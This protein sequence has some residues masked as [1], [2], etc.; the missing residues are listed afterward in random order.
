MLLP[1]KKIFFNLLFNISLFSL[2]LIGI[3]NSSDRKRVNLIYIETIKLP[4]SFIIGMSFISG[5]IAGG[6][7]KISP[8][9]KKK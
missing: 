7:L 1:L 6:L 5:S 3:Q 2:L 8:E 4:I 9:D